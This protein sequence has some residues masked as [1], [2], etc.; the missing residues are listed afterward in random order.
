VP[1]WSHTADSSTV[2]FPPPSHSLRKL[3][4]AIDLIGE[5]VTLHGFIGERIDL[6][7]NFYFV[8]LFDAT[9]YS[10]ARSLQIVSSAKGQTGSTAPH[11]ALKTVQANSPVA[12]RG[13]LKA[14]KPAKT[15]NDSPGTTG[16]GAKSLEIK[17]IELELLDFQV[18]NDFPKDIIV[19]E[20]TVFPPEQRHLQL[21]FDPHLRENL[22]F[23][24]K[25][26]SVCRKV[27]RN[28]GNGGFVEVETPLLFKSTPEGAREFLVPT[29]RKGM[30]YALPQSPQ[31]YKQ[32]LMASG[33]HQYYQIAR[34]FRDEDLRA[35]RQPEFTQV[36]SSVD[37]I[38][39]SLTFSIA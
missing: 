39:R 38:L 35:D 27:L 28:Q 23:R 13:I 17:E 22:R 4:S 32:I 31:Q 18:L 11:S 7:K 19:A 25:V 24:A 2:D 36:G 21:R 12:I 1:S 26:Q 37:G 5:E 14:R 33:T 20:D 29:R 10:Q 6:S 30:A 3:E 34:C 15:E 9:S 8:P 16:K